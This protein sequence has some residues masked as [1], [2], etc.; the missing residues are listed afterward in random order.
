M[1]VLGFL[2]TASIVFKVLCSIHVQKNRNCCLHAEA[3]TLMSNSLPG[4]QC[5]QIKS[6]MGFLGLP[7]CCAADQ[8]G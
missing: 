1:S 3:T 8:E 6:E 5:L 4:C 7:M 2:V